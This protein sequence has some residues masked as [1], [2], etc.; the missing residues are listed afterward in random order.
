MHGFGTWFPLPVQLF[1]AIGDILIL[2]HILW[3]EKS[4]NP[5]GRIY[6]A[7]LVFYGILRFSLEWIR[8]T[9]RPW[10]G[11]SHGHWFSIA[12]IAIGLTMFIVMKRSKKHAQK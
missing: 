4:R 11:M 6:P 7:F 2:T 12:A 8:I 5:E 1:E 3:W 10:L 9:E